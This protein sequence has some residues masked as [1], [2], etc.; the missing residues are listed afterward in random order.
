MFRHIF[1]VAV[2]NAYKHLNYAL[3]NI[4]G[5][6][7]GLT[8]FIFIMIYVTDELKYD[9]FHKNADKTYRVN[10]LYN[11]NNVNEDAATLS[12]PEAE[13]LQNTYPD[14]IKTMCRLFDFQVSTLLFEYVKNEDDIIKYNEEWFYLAD[15]TVF[16]VFTF[17]FVE[18]DMETALDRPGTLVISESTARRYFGKEP[19]MGKVLRLEEGFDAEITGVFR[20]LPSQTHLR[21][22]ILGSLSTFRQFAGGSLP[23]T[24]IW[25]PCWTYMFCRIMLNLNLS[26]PIFLNL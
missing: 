16:D 20:D 1:L 17:S 5:L 11:A 24:W 23:Q 2:R 21:I 10:R 3:I 15:S 6:A 25:N 12:F 19:A 9:K 18:G 14:M 22:D 4:L 7:L 13:G 8:S 26:K